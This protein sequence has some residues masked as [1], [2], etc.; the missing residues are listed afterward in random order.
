MFSESV[1]HCGDLILTKANTQR[2]RQSPECSEKTKFKE[3]INL[4]TLDGRTKASK[5][6]DGVGGYKHATRSSGHLE[7]H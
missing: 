7:C 3:H 4:T 1:S 5:R 2:Q 6:E